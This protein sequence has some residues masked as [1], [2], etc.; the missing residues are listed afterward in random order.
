M[1]GS[2]GARIAASPGFRA[3]VSLLGQR[4]RAGRS[5][6]AQRMLDAIGAPGKVGHEVIEGWPSSTEPRGQVAA[7]LRAGVP[8]PAIEAL[9]LG[10][11]IDD[12]RNYD[13]TNLLKR[14]ATKAAEAAA[15]ENEDAPPQDG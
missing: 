3:F 7:L 4:I 8:F 6:D 13:W 11:Y 1:N 9:W 15:K 14:A 10:S 12:L 2:L 5:I